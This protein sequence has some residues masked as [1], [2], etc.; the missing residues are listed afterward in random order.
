MN[1][2]IISTGRYDYQVSI[3]GDEGYNISNGVR[4]VYRAGDYVVKFTDPDNREYHHD[5]LAVWN[6]LEECDRK[7]FAPIIEQTSDYVVQK[8]VELSGHDADNEEAEDKLNE[9]RHKYGLNDLHSNNWDTTPEGELIIFDYALG[10]GSH[11]DRSDSYYGGFQ[12]EECGSHVGTDYVCFVDDNAYCEHCYEQNFFYCELCEAEHSIDEKVEIV[13]HPDYSFACEECAKNELNAIQC[14]DCED[15]FVSDYIIVDDSN[16]VYCHKCAEDRD[17]FHCDN[18]GENFEYAQRCNVC[19]T[20]DSQV[21]SSVEFPDAVQ[22]EQDITIYY[23]GETKT[24]ENVTVWKL[25][26]A[27]GLYVYHARQIDKDNNQFYVIHEA[28]GLATSN[29]L[30]NFR[31]AILYMGKIGVL[32]DWTVGKDEILKAIEGIREQVFKIRE[33]LNVKG[34]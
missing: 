21:E 2:N 32:T 29:G 5:E 9:L 33:E 19:E 28:C 15:W 22:S 3:D 13:D 12:C 11:S 6:R 1:V 23:S 30:T 16:S 14:E 10:V 24:Y 4:I 20:D 34:R 18:C 31:T 26:C 7:Y 27:K 8:F 17:V 25:E